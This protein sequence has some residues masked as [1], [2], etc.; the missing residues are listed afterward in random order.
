MVL[1]ECEKEV[2]PRLLVI[3]WMCILHGTIN[4]VSN[5]RRF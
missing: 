5:W 3:H 4:V 1:S 2:V